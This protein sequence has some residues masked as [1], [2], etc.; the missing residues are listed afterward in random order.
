[1]MPAEAQ[2]KDRLQ[3]TRQAMTGLAATNGR[4]ASEIKLLAV[5]KMQAADQLRTA[6][7]FG[8]VAFGENYLQEA[9]DKQQKLSDL[10]IEW[11]FI[12]PIQSNKTRDISAHFSWV[13][14]V[15]RLK[16]AKRLSAQRPPELPPLNICLQVN[17]DGEVSKSG[18]APEDIM[19][20]ADEIAALPML[21]LRGLMAIPAPKVSFEE[22]FETFRRVHDIMLKIPTMDTLSMGMSGD[23]PAAI[24]AGSTIVRVGTAI[25]GKREAK[26]TQ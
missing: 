20:L 13:H 22:Q 19:A 10:A 12:G 5:S 14:S 9:L 16:V 7:N 17:I 6:F 1:M 2:L 8:Q 3:Q 15:D 21:N 4:H 11:H 25:F 26:T 24:A 23:M 18:V